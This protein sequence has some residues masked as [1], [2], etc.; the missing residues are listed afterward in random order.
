ML[1]RMEQF[2][3]RPW[4]DDGA[5]FL[6]TTQERSGRWSNTRDTCFALLFLKRATTPVAISGE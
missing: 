5:R 2:G 4:Y 3:E 1:A 6:C